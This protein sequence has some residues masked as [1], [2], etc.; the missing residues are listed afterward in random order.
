MDAEAVEDMESEEQLEENSDAV[1]I[2][3]PKRKE[4]SNGRAEYLETAG[5]KR[6]CDLISLVVTSVF[7]YSY[8]SC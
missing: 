4:N 5:S 3:Q 8:C 1:D 7:L 2:K 6:N